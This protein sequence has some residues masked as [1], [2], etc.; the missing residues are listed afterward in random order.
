MRYLSHWY[1]FLRGGTGFWFSNESEFW[2]GW[3][4]LGL[5]MAMSHI[6]FIRLSLIL[7]MEPM[8]SALI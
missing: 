3:F 8:L 6:Y 1:W 7:Y 4:W 2:L 5:A